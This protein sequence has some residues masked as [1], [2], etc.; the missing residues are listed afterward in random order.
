MS[1][2][3]FVPLSHTATLMTHTAHYTVGSMYVNS[4]PPHIPRPT[5]RLPPPTL[6]RPFH[7]ATHDVLE[8]IGDLLERD[9]FPQRLDVAH[10]VGL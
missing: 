3:A 8:V 7:R 9:Q 2:V 6:S 10:A 1:D 5:H 4:L